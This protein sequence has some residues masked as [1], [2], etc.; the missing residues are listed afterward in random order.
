M[1]AAKVK[2]NL[3]IRQPKKKKQIKEIIF[4]SALLAWPLLQFAVMYIGVNFNSFVLAF[5]GVKYDIVDGEPVRNIIATGNNFK[6]VFEW[7]GGGDPQW[8]NYEGDITSMP[9]G[10][11]LWN[12]V[13]SWFIVN[14]ISIPLGLLFSYYIYKKHP[15]SKFFRVILFLPSVLSVMVVCGIFNWFDFSLAST[16]KDTFGVENA[17]QLLQ[18]ENTQ[19]IVVMAFNIWLNFGVSVLM[20][21][22]KM[23]SIPPEV[24]EAGKIDGVTPI[25]EFW[26]VI[27]PHVYPVLTIF[28][29]TST[30]GIFVNQYNIFTLFLSNARSNTNLATFG[31]WIFVNVYDKADQ[32]IVQEALFPIAAIGLVLTMIAIPLT[33]LTRWLLTKFGPSED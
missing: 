23:S 20:F 4:Y 22:N 10:T 17:Q 32:L 1:K 30:A 24:I 19:Y 25:G 21:T 8:T 2:Q 28:I 7:I 3:N 9:F 29:V 18:N 5:Q 11:L 13:K 27:M 16:L 26:H 14:V 33:L 15:G 6:N 12:S 31:Y